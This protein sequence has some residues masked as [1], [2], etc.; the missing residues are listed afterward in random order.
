MDVAVMV[1]LV[2]T[3]IPVMVFPTTVP[4]EAVTIPLLLKFTLYVVP[5]HIALDTFNIG[6]TLVGPYITKLCVGHPDAVVSIIT[7]VPAGMPVIAVGVNV[8]AFAV[9]TTP[10]GLFIAMLYVLPVQFDTLKLAKALSH[11]FIQLTGEL[12]STLAIQVPEVAVM[13]TF[14]PTGMPVMVLPDTVPAEAVKVEPALLVT[15]TL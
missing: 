5:L 12:T 15:D 14:V 11:G 13:I 10:L 2:P 7:L 9:I 1:T 4:A 3:V 6:A 8:P